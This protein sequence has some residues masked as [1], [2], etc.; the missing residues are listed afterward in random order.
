MATATLIHAAKILIKHDTLDREAI[1]ELK[2]WELPVSSKFPDGI[3]YSLF[4]V[5]TESREVIVG[6]DN[7]HPKGHHIHFGDVEEI[8]FFEGVEKLIDDFYSFVKVRGYSV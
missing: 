2:V 8:Y 5:E 4:C 3:K 6:I 7:H 1:L